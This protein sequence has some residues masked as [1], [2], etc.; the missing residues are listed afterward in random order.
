M[1]CYRKLDPPVNHLFMNPNCYRTSFII[2]PYLLPGS[3]LFALEVLWSHLRP[4]ICGSS[5]GKIFV[6]R[7]VNF[8]LATRVSL[9]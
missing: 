7:I 8:R 6:C 5:P 4:K 3:F 2:E 1:S 9:A